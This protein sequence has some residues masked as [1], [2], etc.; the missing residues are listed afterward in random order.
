MH[1]CLCNPLFKRLECC[2]EYW[3]LKIVCNTFVRENLTGILAGWFIGS[4]VCNQIQNESFTTQFLTHSIKTLC[5][6]NNSCTRN[7]I[8]WRSKPQNSTIWCRDSYTSSSVSTCSREN[9]LLHFT[10][11]KPKYIKNHSDWSIYLRRSLQFLHQPQRQ[12]HLK[13][14]RVHDPE[15]MDL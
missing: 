8:V 9:I 11:D 15:H 1:S 7:R 12:T 10:Y 3:K 6:G 4:L 13:I 14:L 5:H 2:H